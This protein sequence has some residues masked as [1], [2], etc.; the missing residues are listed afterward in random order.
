VDQ[1]V[2]SFDLRDTALIELS[3]SWGGLPRL[4]VSAADESYEVE[5]VHTCDSDPLVSVAFFRSLSD[6]ARRA[7]EELTELIPGDAAG[8]AD[9]RWDNADSGV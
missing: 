2:V 5:F 9:S 8:N 3:R 6:E 7:A 1:Q 4:S